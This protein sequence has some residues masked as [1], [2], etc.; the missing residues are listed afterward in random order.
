MFGINKINPAN[1][2]DFINALAKMSGENVVAYAAEEYGNGY[3]W[4]FS[5]INEGRSDSPIAH[6]A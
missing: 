3:F 4:I 2:Q 5:G 6:S 1:L